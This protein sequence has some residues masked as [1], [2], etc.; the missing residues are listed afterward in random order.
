MDEVIDPSL[1]IN[2][3]N[4]QS[5]LSSNRPPIAENSPPSIDED[6][7]SSSSFSSSSS[8]NGYSTPRI[9]IDTVEVV[10]TMPTTESIRT[11]C[12]YAKYYG[13]EN[14]Q[15][16]T[17]ATDDILRFYDRF[18]RNTVTVHPDGINA[19]C[20]PGQMPITEQIHKYIRSV[21][22]RRILFTQLEADRIAAAESVKAYINK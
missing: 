15:Y 13:E 19:N 12:G 8:S 3:E 10:N 5:Y 9:P 18:P 16:Q 7:N 6:N 2:E 21:D 11:Y 22:N 14:A 1:I 17:L 20:S 4:H